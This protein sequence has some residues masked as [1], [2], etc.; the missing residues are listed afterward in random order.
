MKVSPLALL[1]GAGWT[2]GAYGVGQLLRLMTNIVLARLLAPELFGIMVI[3]NSLR[4]GIDL[5]SDVGIGQN[6]VQ[7][8]NGDDPLFYNTGWSLQQIRGVLLWLVCFAAAAPLAHLYQAPI[9]ISV[10]PVAAFYFILTGC[11]SISVPLLQR[12]LK[13]A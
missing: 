3:V 5:F 6:I 4:T 8:K 1:K 13:F 10:L 12:K 9:L 7:N 2:I 11:T